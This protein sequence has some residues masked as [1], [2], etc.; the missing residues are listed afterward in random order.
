MG[1]IDGGNEGSAGISVDG[2]MHQVG[3]P[4]HLGAAHILV[5]D[6]GEK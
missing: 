3:E 4:G 1:A 2:V 5:A 6:G